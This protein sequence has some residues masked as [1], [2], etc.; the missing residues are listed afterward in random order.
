MSSQ[1]KCVR[2]AFRASLTSVQLSVAKSCEIGLV[3][4]FVQIVIHEMFLA[5]RVEKTARTPGDPS[6]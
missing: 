5:L 4:C 2:V 1:L 3:C 6:S